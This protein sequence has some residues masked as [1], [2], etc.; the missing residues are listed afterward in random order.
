MLISCQTARIRRHYYFCLQFV[1]SLQQ[2][3]RAPISGVLKIPFGLK[4]SRKVRRS[5]VFFTCGTTLNIVDYDLTSSLTWYQSGCSGALSKQPW[6]DSGSGTPVKIGAYSGFNVKIPI[7]RSGRFYAKIH[8]SYRWV[9]SVHASAGGTD[10]NI[11][12]SS[13]KSGLGIGIIF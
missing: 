3:S 5:E 9:N 11:D 1:E 4:I 8:S 2:A 13:W 12:L 7:S 10:V 6:R